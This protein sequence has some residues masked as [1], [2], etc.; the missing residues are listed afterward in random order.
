M[1]HDTLHRTYLKQGT[2]GY[3]VI[4]RFYA[5]YSAALSPSGIVEVED[6]VHEVFVSLSKT[7]FSEVRDIE[8]YVMRAIKLHCWTLLDKAIRA[9]AFSVKEKNENPAEENGIHSLADDAGRHP[10]VTEVEGL[11]LLSFVSLFKSQLRPE[12]ARLLNMLVDGAERSEMAQL[13]QWNMNT[14]DTHIRRLRL[15]LAAYL[16]GLGYSYPSLERFE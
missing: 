2:I 1:D 13:L 8:H 16:R 11:E 10:Q 7:D 14:L 4:R 9:A 12:D 6:V 15:R 5:K 3:A